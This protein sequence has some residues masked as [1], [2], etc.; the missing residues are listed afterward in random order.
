MK[1]PSILEPCKCGSTN[2]I[3][4][5]VKFKQ[6]KCLD[7]GEKYKLGNKNSVEETIR[8]YNEQMRLV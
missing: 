1:R 8:L 5:G 4:N 6:V 2:L 3:I 7:C